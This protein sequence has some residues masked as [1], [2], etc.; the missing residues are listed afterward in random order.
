MIVSKTD[1]FSYDLEKKPFA[2][3]HTHTL[4][5]YFVSSRLSINDIN[6]GSNNTVAAVFY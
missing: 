3:T 2:H 4:K 6:M 1:T 5:A